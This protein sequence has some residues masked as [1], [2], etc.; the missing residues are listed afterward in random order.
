[1][2][3]SN[4]T[5]QDPDNAA[6]EA[7]EVDENTAEFEKDDERVAAGADRAPTPEEE[8][9]AERA[10]DDVDLERVATH[11]QEMMERGAHQKGEGSVP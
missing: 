2:T 10:A 6:D 1:M 11:E 3:D 4:L 5:A 7:Y 9:A 8:A